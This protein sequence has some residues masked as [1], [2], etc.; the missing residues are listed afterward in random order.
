MKIID[1]K[2]KIIVAKNITSVEID[3]N[4]V[5]ISVPE[6]TRATCHFASNQQ[7]EKCFEGIKRF[8]RGTLLVDMFVITEQPGFAGFSYGG[9]IED[10]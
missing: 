4:R 3:D 1:L 5:I 8:L 9:W 10:A 7:A 6:E 2:Y